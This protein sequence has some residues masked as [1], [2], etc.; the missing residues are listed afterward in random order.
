MRQ[1][2]LRKTYLNV[3]V[4][5]IFALSIMVVHPGAILL[6]VSQFLDFLLCQPHAE[7]GLNIDDNQYLAYCVAPAV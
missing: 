4:F 7:C 6:F 3:D 5:E 1:E 2:D